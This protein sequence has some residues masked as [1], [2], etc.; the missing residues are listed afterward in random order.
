[1]RLLLVR[2]GESIC[3]VE[4][5]VGGARGCTGLSELGF[6]QA[7]ALRDRLARE[8]LTADVLLASTLP[9]AVQTAEVLGETLGLQVLRDADLREFD[10]GSL[11]G[12]RWEDWA[13]RFDPA[14]ERDRPLSAGGDSLNGFRARVQALFERLAAA[15]DGKTVVA[16]CHGGIVWMSRR[17][18]VGDDDSQVEVDNTSITEWSHTD[19]EWELVRI[20]DVKHLQRAQLV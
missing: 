3:S 8:G 19:G 2:H 4:G 6:A 5:I 18:F 20:N 9:R 16:A 11:D 7:R 17:L 14:V 15:H 13:D 12:T 1:M 10:P